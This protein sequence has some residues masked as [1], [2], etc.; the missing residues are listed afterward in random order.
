MGRSVKAPIPF[1][2]AYVRSVLPRGK[3]KDIALDATLRTAV[4]FQERRG[5]GRDQPLIVRPGDI[6][7][8]WRQRKV[9][10]CVLF[11]VDASGSMGVQAQMR[12]TKAAILSLL[13][14]AYQ[15]RDRVGL[16]VF[17]GIRARLVLP[18][19]GSVDLARRYL[20]VIPTGGKTP[21]ASG[22]A[23]GLATIKMERLK[24]PGERALMI[25]V[26]DGR[27]NVALN[28]EDPLDDAV[29]VAKRIWRSGVDVLFLDTEV[30]P[31]AFG[32]GWDLARIM[33]ATYLSLEQLDA[34]RLVSLIT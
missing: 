33:K 11:V 21:L 2:G 16:V 25:I 30:D 34:R 18:P 23:L 13:H 27:A 29:M 22:L 19:T 14:R 20:R 10:R 15:N 3:P 24:H 28:G 32:Y 9:G 5:K 4:L 17:Q 26:S 7:V 12:E 8:K 6:R 1:E 31:C